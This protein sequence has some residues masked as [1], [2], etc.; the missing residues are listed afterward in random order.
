MLLKTIDKYILKKFIGTFIFSILLIICIVVIFDISE[1][2]DNFIHASMREIIFDHYLN[3]I[4]F[5]ANKLS[6]L[7]AFISVIFFTSKMAT[8]YETVAILSSGITYRRFL[9]PYIIGAGCIALTSLYLS[10]FVIPKANRHKQAFEDKY[11]NQHY[12]TTD[13]N[14]HRQLGNTVIYMESYSDGDKRCNRFTL[15]KIKNFQQYYMLNADWTQ[16]DTAKKK[17]IAYNYYERI[18]HTDSAQKNSA[19]RYT[20]ELKFGQQK[21]LDINF[22]PIDM[23]RVESKVEVMT[24]PEL[25]KYITEETEKGSS[26]IE[27]FEVENYMRTAFP[28]ST[29]ILT[30]IGVCISSRRVRGGIGL[31]LAMGLLLAASY[32]L[33]SQVSS[34][35]AI[36]GLMSPFIAV[37][38]PNVLYGVVAFYLYRTAQK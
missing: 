36:N 11:I 21:E 3:F 38:I 26:G 16:W 8:R 34:T 13:R 24:Y 27:R 4:P 23:G 17:W 32:M 19:K 5:F 6:P 15:E 14:I 12:Q 9:R 25:K 35:F 28:F 22:K 20:E 29:F 10:H 7:F 37:W 33:F 31:H 1:K 30:I 2:I 18:M